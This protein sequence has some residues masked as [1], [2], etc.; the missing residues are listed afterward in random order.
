MALTAEEFHARRRAAWDELEELVRS[1][2]GG[3]LRNQPVARLER[4]GSLYRTAASDL[5][6]ARRDFPGEGVT[7]YLNALVARAHPLIHRGRPLRP[8]AL[9]DFLLRGIPRRF[10]AYGGHVALS[11]A[12]L[13]AGIAGGWLAVVLRPDIASSIV[14]STSLFDKMARGEIPT[15]TNTGFLEAAAIFG[16]NFRVALLLF[17]GGVLV[18]IPTV[19]NLLLNGWTLGTLAAAEHRDGL[20]V[21]FWSFIAPHGVV[22]LSIFVLA[23]ATGLMLADA[24]LRPGL[25]RRTDALA[26]VAA[27]AA[28]MAVGIASLLI[29]CALVEGYLSP[30]S[31]PEGLKYAVGIVLGAALYA[32]LLLSGREPRK[33]S[34]RPTLE[35]ASAAGGSLGTSS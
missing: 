5:A 25:L 34:P 29:T 20:D 7:D 4:L 26:R 13:V 27:D 35:R 11:A 14:P 32:W 31:A 23:G 18:G 12:L 28:V 3:A 19:L 2:G 1:S 8:A 21:T 30:S 9:G 17:A 6:I 15:G 10:R 33:P 16:N 22:E 24:I